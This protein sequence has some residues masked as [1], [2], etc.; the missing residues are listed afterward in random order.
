MVVRLL[1][2]ERYLKHAHEFLSYMKRRFESN[3]VTPANQE[4]TATKTR[5]R[6]LECG[7]S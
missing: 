5:R 2:H 1:T 4:L 3:V 6:P 7:V